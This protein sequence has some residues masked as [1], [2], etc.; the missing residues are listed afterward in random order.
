MYYCILYTLL[1]TL[2]IILYIDLLYTEY[3]RPTSFEPKKLQVPVLFPSEDRSRSVVPVVPHPMGRS[4]S[5][6]SPSWDPILKTMI[7]LLPDG[8][9]TKNDGKS[10]LFNG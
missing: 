7:G 10:P 2:Y 6:H 9:H 1:V 5:R 4:H 3:P 8:K